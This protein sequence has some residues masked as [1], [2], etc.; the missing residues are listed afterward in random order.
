MLKISKKV[1]TK[2]ILNLFL[3][4]IGNILVAFGTAT[5]LVNLNIVSG[6]LSGLGIICQ[7]WFNQ[8]FGSSFLNGQFID[9][10]VFILTWILWLIGL[11]VL[12]KDFAFKTLVAAIIYPIAL[13][14]F[15]RVDVFVNLADTIC[16]YPTN[17]PDDITI[18]NLLLCAIFGGVFVGGGVALSFLGGGSTG[19]VDVIIAILAKYTPIKSSVISFGLDAI[20]VLLGIFLI[21]NNI[22]PGLCGVI[23]AFV[24][25]LLVEFVYVGNQTA[26]QCDIIS[27]HYE[28]IREYVNDTLERGSTLIEVKGGYQKDDHIILRV[29]FNKDEYI[30]IKEYI[31]KVDPKAFVT[32]T[33]TNAVYGEGFRVNKV[34]ARKKKKVKKDIEDE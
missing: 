13:T 18:G 25:A 27:D 31:A 6:G 11:L 10:V 8:W 2:Q 23:A 15:I 7:Y 21:P 20:V 9:I 19:G 34:L 14:I 12:G 3:I 26:Y 17:N 24:T 33:Q 30:R 22:V 29:V 28:E 32:F 4:V 16:Y 1:L 5:F